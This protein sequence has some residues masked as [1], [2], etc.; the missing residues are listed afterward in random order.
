MSKTFGLI[1]IVFWVIPFFIH[2]SED[3]DW[4]LRKNEEGIKVY[5][6]AKPGAEIYMYKVV[7]QISVKPEIIYRQVIDFKEN[8][9]HME[10]VDSLRLLD[11]KKDERY[12][13]YMRF[14]MPWPVKNREMVMQMLVTQD[15]DGIY[16]ESNDVPESLSKSSDNIPIADFQEKWIIKRGASDNQS[17][18][19]VTGWVDPGGSVPLWV[20]NLFS[21]RTP[22]RFISGI[23][24]EVKKEL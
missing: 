13:N 8:L 22:F 2:A 7:T 23:I 12:V 24:E 10:L 1:L 19:T 9:K 4:Q 17:L 20:V 18:I 3:D 14:N 21:A 6:R 15:Q 5:T 11:H 16:L